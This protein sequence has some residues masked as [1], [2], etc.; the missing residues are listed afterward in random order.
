MINSK[1]YTLC[2]YRKDIIF[3][4]C[5]LL[6]YD[7]SHEYDKCVLDYSIFINHAGEKFDNGVV[8]YIYTDKCMLFKISCKDKEIYPFKVICKVGVPDD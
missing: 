6:K 3:D 7:T 2:S 8:G 1:L 5:P 4:R